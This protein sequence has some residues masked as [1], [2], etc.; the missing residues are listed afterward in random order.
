MT[1]FVVSPCAPT[2]DSRH[3]HVG[4]ELA[5]GLVEVVHL[6]E[7]AAYHQDN[8][9]IG[10]RMRELI[11]SRECH[12]QRDAERLDEHD[13]DGASRRANGEVNQRVL[14]TVL[15][16]DLV[17]HDDGEDSDKGAVEEEAYTSGCVSAC[18]S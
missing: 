11:V 18:R 8:E 5:K 14:A 17:D 7:N 15:G 1:L 6:C 10:R 9:D 2:H 12:L 16:R 3:I 4:R 13:R